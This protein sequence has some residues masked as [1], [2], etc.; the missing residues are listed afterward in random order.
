MYS[1]AI[2]IEREEEKST[3]KITQKRRY[4]KLHEK[5]GMEETAIYLITECPGCEGLRVAMLGRKANS[6]GRKH[7][8][9]SNI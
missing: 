5:Y 3:D 6:R 4:S 1:L 9:K 8:R 2:T 7:K